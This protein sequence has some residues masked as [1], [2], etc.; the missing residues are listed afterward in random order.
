[1]PNDNEQDIPRFPDIPLDKVTKSKVFSIEVD[2]IETEADRRKLIS[3]LFNSPEAAVYYFE[4]RGGPQNELIHQALLRGDILAPTVEFFYYKHPNFQ[5][6]Y[7]RIQSRGGEYKFD[8]QKKVAENEPMFTRMALSL[9]E[10]KKRELTARYQLEL[11]QESESSN[12]IELKPGFGGVSID[13]L[14]A[15]DWIR[16]KGWR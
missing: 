12:P 10:R 6:D 2:D 4:P 11:Q 1:M 16:P 9:S 5:H 3:L 14:K 7:V 13:L 8:W 15:W